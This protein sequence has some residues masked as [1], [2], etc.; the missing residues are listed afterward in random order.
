[1]QAVVNLYP[2]IFRA[3]ATLAEVALFRIR[4]WSALACVAHIPYRALAVIRAGLFQDALAID[5]FAVGWTVVLPEAGI[6]NAPPVLAPVSGATVF[7]RLA[8]QLRAKAVF[9]NHI[10]RAVVVSPALLHR[11]EAL[12]LNAGFARTAINI[13]V[14]IEGNR[15]GWRFANAE[16]AYCRLPP[17]VATRPALLPDALQVIR[18]AYHSRRTDNILA[19]TAYRLTLARLRVAHGSFGAD[20]AVDAVL[21]LGDAPTRP[22]FAD[23]PRRATC[24][25]AILRDFFFD[26]LTR[27]FVTIETFGA[28]EIVSAV[29]N[30]FALTGIPVALASVRADSRLA[31][32]W[33]VTD[34]FSRR[35]VALELF[36]ANEVITAVRDDLAS[37]CLD[38]A[39]R[40]FRTSPF[41][42]VVIGNAKPG[43]PI[44]IAVRV[45]DFFLM[46]A[47]VYRVAPI[48]H[49]VTVVIGRAVGV[50][51]AFAVLRLAGIALCVAV[52]AEW[53]FFIGLALGLSPNAYMPLNVA[54][55][56]IRAI[57]VRIALEG[58][59]ARAGL[60]VAYLP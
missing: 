57:P 35:A 18:V 13:G 55:I 29:W 7:V 42:A 16:S 24:V 4:R 36:W 14:A 46:P 2:A 21:R 25:S 1:M 23:L 41:P 31:T 59:G 60:F 51:T 52:I 49:K 48:F 50:I 19:N 26:A 20:A 12:S 5:A 22:P 43:S 10:G 47:V 9:T 32:V 40:T 17:A 11:P 33:E 3:P 44:A 8:I 56:S 38:I 37:A 53:A 39:F 15:F 54:C 45:A 27:P 30:G 6:V 28:F 58:E 34:A